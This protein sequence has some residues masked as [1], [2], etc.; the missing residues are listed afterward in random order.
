MKLQRFLIVLTGVNLALLIFLLSQLKPVAAQGDLPVLR[1]RALEIV[2]MQGRVRASIAINP[3]EVVDSVAYPESVLLRMVASP[4]AQGGPAI[5]LQAST[6]LTGLRLAD[7][8]ETGAVELRAEA[9]GNS[10]RVKN[11]DG[12]EQQLKP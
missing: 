4:G 12:R 5:K 11:R 8:T 6:K 2:D 1:G 10:I 7:G 9:V 3:P